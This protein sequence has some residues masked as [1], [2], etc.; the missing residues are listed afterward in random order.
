MKTIAK[1][2]LSAWTD[3][4]NFTLWLQKRLKRPRDVKNVRA[5]NAAHMNYIK[6]ATI[7]L[8][9][10]HSKGLDEEFVKF[11]KSVEKA[12]AAV[13]VE[14]RAVVTGKGYSDDSQPPIIPIIK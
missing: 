14:E 10:I 1:K 7:A 9:F 5:V 8:E 11:E 2:L 13:V 3:Q 4:T 6:N 12:V